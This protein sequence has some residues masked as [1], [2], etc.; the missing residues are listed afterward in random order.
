MR[1]ASGKCSADCTAFPCCCTSNVTTHA[2]ALN[3]KKAHFSTASRLNTAKRKSQISNLRSGHT[4]SSSSTNGSVTTIGLLISASAKKNS[5]T[6]KYRAAGC[7]LR[8][9]AEPAFVT[10]LSPRGTARS[11]ERRVDGGVVAGRS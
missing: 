2:S 1:P 3:K 4:S 10:R 8:D 7:G 6:K 11:E 5:D 9:A